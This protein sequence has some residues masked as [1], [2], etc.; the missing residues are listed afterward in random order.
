M[1]N[2]IVAVT[3]YGTHTKTHGGKRV[4][5]LK[6]GYSGII[7]Q[8]LLILLPSAVDVS[9]KR[10]RY[11]YIHIPNK[12]KLRNNWL[13]LDLN[14]NELAQLEAKTV[15]SS[16]SYGI[17]VWRNSKW[18]LPP[19]QTQPEYHD[20][21][22]SG[23][24]PKGS[25][26]GFW[27][28]R[29]D[30]TAGP[31]GGIRDRDK[32]IA[33][34]SKLD[35][36]KPAWWWIAGNDATYKNLSELKRYGCRW[37]RN[38]RAFACI[39]DNLPEGLLGL[40]DNAE[41]CR[42][43]MNGMNPDEAKQKYRHITI[44]E[45]N[46]KPTDVTYIEEHDPCTVEEAKSMLGIP[47]H[48]ADEPPTAYQRGRTAWTTQNIAKDI[49]GRT[50]HIPVGT[51]YT[52]DD[53]DFSGDVLNPMYI[54]SYGDNKT[55]RVL[56]EELIPMR[57]FQIG[58]IVYARQDT[59]TSDSK[60]IHTGAKG[61]IRKLYR[62]NPNLGSVR[63]H[64]YDVEW[65]GIGI[66][67]MFEDELSAIAP[68]P[69]I[70][71]TRGRIIPEGQGNSTADDR[72][73]ILEA[74]HKSVALAVVAEKCICEDQD[75]SIGW[76]PAKNLGTWVA[77]GICNPHGKN[78]PVYDPTSSNAEKPPAIRI[79]KPAQLKDDDD[80]AQAIRQTTLQGVTLV[81]S[82]SY[83][84]PKATPLPMA[85]VGELTGSVMANV[86]CYGYAL[87]GDQLIFLNMG[88][89]RSGIEAIRAKL[90]QGHIVNLSQWDAPSIE[91]T[92]GEGNT[93]VYTAYMTN[94]QEARFVHC[95]LA[96]ERLVTPN[97]NGNAKTYIMQISEDQAKGQ[98]LHHV[99][100]TVKLPVFDIWIEY[101]WQAGQAAKLIRNTRTGGGLVIKTIDLDVDGWGRLIQYGIAENTIS[102]PQL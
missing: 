78:I 75:G 86:H 101:L 87:D 48:L 97:Y 22:S 6:I 62:F 72:K 44:V 33:E 65:E 20:P 25:P 58:N 67:W 66:E 51:K 30:G 39:G 34:Y 18:M 55:A 54:I 14:E 17:A 46:E 63:G 100:E 88:G 3:T 29:S 47:S 19:S 31:T 96:H 91:L 5:T 26:A 21:R 52:I 84:S 38:R 71:I 82:P 90:S 49:E 32:I 4:S 93:G 102:I 23:D 43:I 9:S 56:E 83:V 40:L 99:R 98:L 24:V 50:E 10:D 76:L 2:Q 16:H 59:K 35:A 42:A 45:E 85:C 13:F 12:P 95:M 69:N 27:A 92:A 60:Q 77:C 81:S 64:T 7:S 8:I 37:K 70:H 36:N 57:L 1:T 74:G 73:A 89:P 61:T 79:M 80:I 28:I 15:S 68:D 94:M 53:I 41:E 11:V